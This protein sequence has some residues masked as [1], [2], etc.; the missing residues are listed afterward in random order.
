M[1]LNNQ[2]SSLLLIRCNNICKTVVV[3]RKAC[4]RYICCSNGKHLI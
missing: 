2:N 4:G 3:V 1:T